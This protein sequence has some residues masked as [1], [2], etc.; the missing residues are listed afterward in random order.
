MIRKPT[1]SVGITFLLF[2]LFIAGNWNIISNLNNLKNVTIENINIDGKTY[3]LRNQKIYEGNK[4]LFWFIPTQRQTVKKVVRL[5]G[6]YIWNKEDPLFD[7]PNLDVSQLKES[8]SN[9]TNEQTLFLKSFR[10]TTPLY[11]S[12]FL[13]QFANTA[14]LNKEFMKN[15]SLSK[16]NEL[17]N[18]QIKTAQ[19]YK[20]EATS[21][22]NFLP[23]YNKKAITFNLALSI[24]TVKSDIGKIVNNGDS[25][26][27]EISKR[28][29]CLAGNHCTRPAFSFGKPSAAPKFSSPTSTFLGPDIVYYLTPTISPRGPYSTE[30]A[31]VGWGKNFTKPVN[32]FYI[33]TIKSNPPRVNIQLATDIFFRPILPALPGEKQLA[34]QGIKY[35]Y[36]GT[37]APYNCPDRTFFAEISELDL[38]LQN[39]KPILQNTLVDTS[40]SQFEKTFFEQ[41]NPSFQQLLYLS[42]IYGYLYKQLMQDSNEPWITK[43]IPYKEELLQRSISIQR[44]IGSLPLVLNSDI[45]YIIGTREREEFTQMTDDTDIKSYLYPFRNFYGIMFLT[46]SPSIWRSSDNLTYIDRVEVKGAFNPIGGFISL[47][48]AETLYPKSTINTWYNAAKTISPDYF[49]K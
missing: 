19:I 5:S 28:A 29:Q 16:A 14:F 41:K 45:L 7:S 31:C 20:E 36:T 30:T 49:R 22:K 47:S 18:A 3:A 1:V 24:E 39:K 35:I 6:F 9:L 17:I 37:T 48:Q 10:Q 12:G 15:P 11:P 33:K 2:F 43:M 13:V 27:E 44:K 32:Y 40:Y 26:L 34:D 4:Q 23:D 46:F 21:L 25:L 42:Q 38:F 8:A